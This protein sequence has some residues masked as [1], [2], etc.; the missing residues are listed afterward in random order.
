[1]PAG[2]LLAGVVEQS[3]RHVL[4]NCVAAIQSDSIGRLDF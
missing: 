3:L 1:M 4:P 2:T